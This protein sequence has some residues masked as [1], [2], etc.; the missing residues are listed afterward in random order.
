MNIINYL[1]LMT[2]FIQNILHRIVP[3]NCYHK[4]YFTE[5]VI[6]ESIITNSTSIKLDTYSNNDYLKDKKLISISPGGFKG[7]YLLGT[8]TYIKEN[9]DLSNYIFS[10]ASAGAWCSLIMS[11]NKKFNVL[12]FI[13]D[14]ITNSI[15][16]LDLEKK[17]KNKL[18]NNYKE[19]DFDLKRLYIG[20]TSIQKLQFQTNI[21]SDFKN[22]EDAIE[23]C[24]ASS[25]V[26]FITGGLFNNYNNKINFDG[27]FARYPYVG[28]IIPTLHIHPNIWMNERAKLFFIYDTTLLSNEK[29]NYKKLYMEGYNDAEKNKDFLSKTFNKN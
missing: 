25:H 16:I 18:L 4:R 1:L 11:M 27:G 2:S 8:L 23:C 6:T 26:P 17:I 15:S 28:Q 20:V 9:Y 3:K 22:L 14:S 12:D 29:Y 7:F 10:G 5:N 24:I 13:D 21:Y 19:T